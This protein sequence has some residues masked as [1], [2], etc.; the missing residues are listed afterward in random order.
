MPRPLAVFAGQDN[1]GSSLIEIATR[2]GIHIPEEIAVLGV[3]NT[4][5][6]CEG[7][8]IPLSSVRTRLYEVGYYAA[9]QLDRLMSKEIKNSEPPILVS[10]HG[11]ISRQSTDIL[12]IEHPG[13]ATAV[14]YIK[15]HF[16]K[17]ITIEEIIEHVGLSK[18][19]L[20]KAFEKH[21]GRSPASELRRLRLD[22]AKRLLTGTKDKIDSIAFDCGYSNSSNLSCAFRRDTGMSPRNYRLKFGKTEEL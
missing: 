2:A 13:V 14:R 21:L 10:P 4:E 20:E 18:R 5:L 3:D 15:E 8:P 1:L 17:P 12:A 6:L 19:G 11:I 16:S 9:S 7:S 22:N